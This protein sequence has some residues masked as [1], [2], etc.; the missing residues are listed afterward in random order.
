M[1]MESLPH[2]TDNVEIKGNPRVSC[3]DYSE[4][5]LLNS[6]PEYQEKIDLALSVII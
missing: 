2:G 5:S 4:R 3:T 6:A 1:E